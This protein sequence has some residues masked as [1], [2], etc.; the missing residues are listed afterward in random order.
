[1]TPKAYPG[2][3]SAG[4]AA[5]TWMG[6]AGQRGVVPIEVRAGTLTADI[7]V[8]PPPGQT[9][10]VNFGSGATPA[11]GDFTDKTFQTVAYSPGGA[12]V[13]AVTAPTNLSGEVAFI[14]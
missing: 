14:V 12:K 8:V 6:H 3:A 13:A 11:T 1:M 5:G 2:Q 7:A 10:T 4:R 9:V